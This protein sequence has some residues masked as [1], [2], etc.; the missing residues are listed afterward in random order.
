M[1]EEINE[2]FWISDYIQTQID[3]NTDLYKF[4]KKNKLFSKF[5]GII[6]S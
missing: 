3:N 6:D 4:F 5:F 2:G 1:V